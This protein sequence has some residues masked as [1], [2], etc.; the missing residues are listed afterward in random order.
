MSL[1][2]NHRELLKL[3]AGLEGG[4]LAATLGLTA[5]ATAAAAASWNSANWMAGLPN[6]FKR[7]DHT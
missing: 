5:T 7:S 4:A 3:G 2:P 6:G 1:N